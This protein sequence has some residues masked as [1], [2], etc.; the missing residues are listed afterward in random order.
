MLGPRK[1]ASSGRP[2][3]IASLSH[4]LAGSMAAEDD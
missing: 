1:V 4:L 3:P 2:N